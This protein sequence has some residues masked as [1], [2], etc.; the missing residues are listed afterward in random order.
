MAGSFLILAGIISVAADILWRR[1]KAS[2]L[3]YKHPDN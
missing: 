3:T 1:K 2:D